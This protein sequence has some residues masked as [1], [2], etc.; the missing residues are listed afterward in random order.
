MKTCLCCGAD[1]AS[2]LPTCRDCGEA[3]FASAVLPI[4]DARL[5]K[6][7]AS[8]TS[9]E[10]AASAVIDDN[11]EDASPETPDNTGSAILM[12]PPTIPDAPRG[13]RSARR[14]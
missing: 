10:P 8:V 14:S 5:V 4:T 13:R 3:S 1:N 11:A 9:I 6:M 2:F 7:R 12:D